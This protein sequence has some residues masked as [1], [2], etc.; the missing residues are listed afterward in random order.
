MLPTFLSCNTVPSKRFF[1]RHLRF[2]F[3]LRSSIVAFLIITWILL[4]TVFMLKFFLENV[5]WMYNLHNVVYYNSVLTYFPS[6]LVF[7]G[8]QGG[9]VVKNLPAKREM[10]IWFL[11]RE[12]LL[13]KEMA[14][15]F[16]VL[17]WRIPW[18]KKP[19]VLPGMPT[20]THHQGP[21]Q[22]WASR[23]SSG[24]PSWPSWRLQVA[25]CSHKGEQE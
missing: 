24:L 23:E 4:N 20:T 1:Q 25:S 11:S 10:R 2:E 8:F 12:D 21:L 6:A 14:T 7:L 9:S 15:H 13:E 22:C 17:A 19:S 18:T 16:T 5:I 3:L